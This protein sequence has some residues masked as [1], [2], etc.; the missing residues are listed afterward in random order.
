MVHSLRQ[1]IANGA[2][3]FAVPGRIAAETLRNEWG[4]DDKPLVPL[5]NLINEELFGVRVTE[6]RARRSAL[7][8][9]F[10]LS[11]AEFAI[12]WPTRLHERTKGIMNF[13]RAVE[14]TLDSR[15][16]ILIAGEGPDRHR[17]ESWLAASSMSGVT[18]LGWQ[19]EERMLELYASCDLLLLPSLR[20]PNPLSVIEGLWAGLPLLI[21]DRCGNWPEAVEQGV[22]GWVVDPMS[23]TQVRRTFEEI[24]RLTPEQ[25]AGAGSASARIARNKFSTPANVE[26]FADCV[27]RMA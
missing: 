20:D 25:L 7:R 5:P 16:K 26:L 3:A 21:S 11:N 23:Q 9:S 1:W 2:D 19:S 17:L 18:L 15:V 27:V 12:L 4:L 6:L 8:R 22:N 10:G 24:L 14:G 13:L